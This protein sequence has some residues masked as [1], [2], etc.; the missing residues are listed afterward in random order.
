LD[1]GVLRGLRAWRVN[2][3]VGNLLL[4]RM[5]DKKE[6]LEEVC[7]QFRVD[8]EN[9]EIDEILKLLEYVPEEKLRAYEKL[10]KRGGKQNAN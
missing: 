5:M 3:R 8:V 9:W 1:G 10:T 6:L 2:R 7:M 4:E